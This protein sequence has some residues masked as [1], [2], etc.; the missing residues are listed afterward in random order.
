MKHSQNAVHEVRIIRLGTGI[1]VKDLA[2]ESTSSEQAIQ[3]LH[4]C[5]AYGRSDQ[6]RSVRFRFRRASGDWS[7]VES[8]G[9]FYATSLRSNLSSLL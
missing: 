1:V 8:V 7:D 3:I 5:L 2:S 9:F 4:V 6:R